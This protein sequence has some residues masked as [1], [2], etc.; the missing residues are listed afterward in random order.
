MGRQEGRGG[1]NPR[2]PLEPPP[3]E[4][5]CLGWPLPDPAREGGRGPVAR[6]VG[7][8]QGCLSDPALGERVRWAVLPQC[9]GLPCAP[10]G[11]SRPVCP[12]GARVLLENS[13]PG[14]RCPRPAGVTGRWE[15]GEGAGRCCSAISLLGGPG[16]GTLGGAR[17]PLAHPSARV[18][19]GPSDAFP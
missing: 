7:R 14:S 1:L 17:G 4:G 12:A 11:T 5:P 13:C 9:S 15:G 2:S 18:L 8:W 6:L 19:R 16:A 3:R 10:G